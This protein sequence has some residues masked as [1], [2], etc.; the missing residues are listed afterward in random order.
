MK[1]TGFWIRTVV[2]LNNA[3]M[4]KMWMT[5]MTR[6][7]TLDEYPSLEVVGSMLEVSTSNFSAKYC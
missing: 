3:V 7:K 6:E 1:T 2:A 4:E 5:L